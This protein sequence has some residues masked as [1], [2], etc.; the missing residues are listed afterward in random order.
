MFDIHENKSK[1]CI[2]EDLP[3]ELLIFIFGYLSAFDLYE[4]LFHL[5][6]RFNQICFQQKLHF[7]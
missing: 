6:Y 5:N 7:C 2:L 1:K 3:N 4:S